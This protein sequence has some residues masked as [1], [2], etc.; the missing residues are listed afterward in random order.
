MLLPRNVP[1]LCQ[2]PP[3]EHV[4]KIP[5]TKTVE[6][7]AT[8]P[9]PR[10]CTQRDTAPHI[11]KSDRTACQPYHFSCF[12][13]G[14]GNARSRGSE[15]ADAD[16]PRPE[17]QGENTFRTFPQGRLAWQSPEGHGTTLALWPWGGARG[18]LRG[19]GSYAF[20]S[21]GSTSDSRAPSLKKRARADLVTKALPRAPGVSSSL[22]SRWSGWLLGCTPRCAR[23]RGPRGVGGVSQTHNAQSRPGTPWTVGP[24]FE[25]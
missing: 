4:V 18:V 13:R 14:W 16:S 21:R 6:A 22:V 7:S 20:S 1:Q 9:K 15:E 19:G 10:F 23:G 3:F 25:G 24:C 2:R 11:S 17:S 5:K 8:F 12:W